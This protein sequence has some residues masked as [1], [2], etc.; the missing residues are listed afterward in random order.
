MSRSIDRD[1]QRFKKIVRGKVRQNLRKYVTHGEMIGRKGREL[2]SIPVPNVEI[3]H[4]RHGQKGS[5]G[6]GQGEGEEG[7]PIGR[8][9]QDGDGTGQAGDQPGGHI[10]EVEVTLDELAEMLGEALEL[11]NIEP[12]GKNN[13]T[14][15]KDRYTSIRPTG[16]DSLRHFKRTYKR[17]LRRQ[18]ASNQ[19]DPQKPVIIPTSDDERFRSWKTVEEPETNAAIIYMMDVSGSMTDEQKEIV[20]IESFWIDTWLQ[21]QYDGVQRRV[22]HPRCR[23]PRSR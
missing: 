14:S 8:G 12:K 6:V 20:R 21:K 7:Q 22:H 5:G 2:V 15:K 3:P 19:Y 16:P 1:T 17:A 9:Q 13:I 10:R 4:F 23:R 11:P 18:I